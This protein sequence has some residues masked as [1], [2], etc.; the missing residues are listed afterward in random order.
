MYKLIK[1]SEALSMHWIL[2]G[3]I[4]LHPRYGVKLSRSTRSV[5]NQGMVRVTRLHYYQSSRVRLILETT[6]R[7]IGEICCIC[8]FAEFFVGTLFFCLLNI[9]KKYVEISSNS[10]YQYV[11]NHRHLKARVSRQTQWDLLML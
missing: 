2:D 4:I 3:I 6:E 8:L 7:Q 1:K 5:T 9:C 10:I 11:C